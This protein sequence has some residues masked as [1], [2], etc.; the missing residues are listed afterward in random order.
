MFIRTALLKKFNFINK[1][2][3]C[4]YLFFLVPAIVLVG[5]ENVE[6]KPNIP[7][8]LHA[9]DLLATSEIETMIGAPLDGMPK[10]TDK[11][12]SVSNF[13]MSMCNYYSEEKNISIGI[14]IKPHGYQVHGAE[15]FALYEAELQ[16]ELG[17]KYQ[18]EIVEGI[19]EH[20]GWDNSSGQLTIIQ[21]SFMV[22]LGGSGPQLKGA[23]S[24]ELSKK[25]AEKV[26]AQFPK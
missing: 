18:L 20:A 4:G 16:E 5:C 9:C 2:H 3:T 8:M 17:T 24:L 19:G 26:L 23:A 6:K 1:M 13:W 7:E 15:A 12:S 11:T 14:M 10:K 22:I 21:G 25:L